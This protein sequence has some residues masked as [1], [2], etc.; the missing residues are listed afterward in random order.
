M[1]GL[2]KGRELGREGKERG[3]GEAQLILASTSLTC[4]G[5]TVSHRLGR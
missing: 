3:G 1:G 4:Q 5:D 2:V